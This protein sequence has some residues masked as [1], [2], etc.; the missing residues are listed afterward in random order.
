LFRLDERDGLRAA[1]VSE[2]TSAPVR[3]VVVGAGFAGTAVTVALL[4]GFPN[5]P[6]S[7]ALVERSGSF[8]R[9]IA[10]ATPDSQHLLNVPAGGMS[11]VTGQ[12]KHLL[13][14]THGRGLDVTAATYLPRR[15]YGDYLEELLATTADSRV[16][17]EADEAVGLDGGAVVTAGSRARRPD[18]R[19]ASVRSRPHRWRHPTGPVR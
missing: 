12:P 3:V 11:A 4:R 2:V 8:G 13:E 10:Y 19:R 5:L 1:R 18:H 16:R 15:V 17:R 14:W 7:I 6:M 9:G